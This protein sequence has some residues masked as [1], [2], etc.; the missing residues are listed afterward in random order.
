MSYRALVPFVLLVA[1]SEGL[2]GCSGSG[3]SSCPSIDKLQTDV[4]IPRCALPACHGG[5]PPTGD[6]DLGSP[7]VADRLIGVP[8]AQCEGQT[9]VVAGD[10]DASYL[11]HKLTDATPPCGSQMPLAGH[12]TGDEKKQIRCWIASLA[13]GGADGGS[14]T[15][16]AGLT[17][18]EP[19][20]AC[21]DTCVDTKTDPAHCGDCTTSCAVACSGG[22][23]VESCPS[24][25][26]NCAGACV[27]TSS[28]ASHCGDCATACD[29][30]KVCVA[31][32]CSCGPDASFATDIQPIFTANC[33]KAGCHL[34]PA[35]Q[36]GLN[37][38][39]GNAYAN[40]VGVATT[41]CNNRT[42]VVAGDVSQSYIY[43]KIT[44]VDL[45]TGSRMP[46]GQDP[47]PA[48]DIDAIRRWI[49]NGAADN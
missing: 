31:S 35:P 36:Q 2:W 46:K 26:E 7:N 1:T 38:S 33:A 8:A 20:T 40:L 27:D 9:R 49:C 44:G 3:G 14:G 30:G 6:L 11:Y 47:L 34:G 32:E 19:L 18:L 4:L 16:D 12:L 17:C 41:E 28:N 37:L 10:P 21:G 24:P 48:E 25:E 43:N 42:R 5:D 22:S 45:C 23:C 39:E 15:P 13:P 29:P